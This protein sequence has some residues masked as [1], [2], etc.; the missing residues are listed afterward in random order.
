[1]QRD[2]FFDSPEI[3]SVL[4]AVRQTQFLLQKMSYDVAGLGGTEENLP[5]E[6][7]SGSDQESSE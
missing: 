4:D 2:L 5:E 7:D 6:V 1:M 3:R